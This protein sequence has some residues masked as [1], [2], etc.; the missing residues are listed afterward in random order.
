MN[1]IFYVYGYL[2]ENFIP[3]YIG[4][5]KWKRVY[6]HLK[7]EYRNKHLL[8]KIKKIQKE[9]RKDPNIIF[10]AV[11]IPEYKALSLEKFMI[12]HFGR[13]DLG[14]GPLVNLT[15]GGDGVSGHRHSKESK[16]KMS[17]S[18]KGRIPPNKGVPCST[19]QKLKISLACKGYK[20]TP[21]AKQK[22]SLGNKGKSLSEEHKKKLC[23]VLKGI[24]KSNEHKLKLSLA[25]KGKSP[26]NKGIPLSEITKHK[27]STTLK[28][29]PLSEE[30]K[31]KI[32]LAIKGKPSKLKGRI[33]TEQEKLEKYSHRRYKRKNV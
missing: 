21:E 14:L 4:K 5:G 12:K 18:L 19:E 32:S 1:S 31:F 17:N 2:D 23:L 6:Y 20:H 13:K 3:F 7:W 25:N 16:L 27:I 30:T 15:D 28:G 22:I 24:P 33:F 26:P 8:H 29:R 9:T 11:D 10:Y